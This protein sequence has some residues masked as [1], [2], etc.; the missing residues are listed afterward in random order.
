[1][2]KVQE[3]SSE[4]LKKEIMANAKSLNIAEKWAETIANKTAKHVDAWVKGRGV[5]TESDIR[6]VACEKLEILSPD[7]AYIYKNH[8]K[9]L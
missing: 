2:K 6:R 4:R 7:I 8:G 9:I 1:M 3:Y 5:V